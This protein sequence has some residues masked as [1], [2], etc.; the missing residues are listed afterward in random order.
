MTA[1]KCWHGWVYLA[2]VIDLYSRAVVGWALA[3]HMRTSL[4]TEALIDHL[5]SGP[6]T[7]VASTL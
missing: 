4:V 6:Q 1:V 7:S 2:V 3:D 5:H